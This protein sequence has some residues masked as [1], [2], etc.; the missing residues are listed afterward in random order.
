MGFNNFPQPR[1]HNG[2]WDSQDA[3]LCSPVNDLDGCY[4]SAGGHATYEGSP[5]LYQ[6][7]V[8]GDMAALVKKLGGRKSFVKRLDKLHD[9][10][11]LWIGDEQAFFTTFQYHYAGRPG[12]SSQRAHSYIPRLFNDTIAGL[13]GND[14][15]GSM[16][17]FVIFSMLGVYPNPGQSVYLIVPPFFLEVSIT[18]PQTHKRATIRNVNFAPDN[19]YIQSAKLNGKPYTKNWISHAFFASGGLLELTLGKHESDWGTHED[20]VPPSLSTGLFLG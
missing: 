16:G 19:I 7:Y 14:D 13:P 8:P 9:S 1:N 6:F 12:L 18:N 11:V 2:S 17:A 10:G 5:W 15:G 4:L 20:D 3:T